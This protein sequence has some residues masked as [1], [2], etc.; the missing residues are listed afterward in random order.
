MKKSLAYIKSVYLS[1]GYISLPWFLNSNLFL[2]NNFIT[3]A[4]VCSCEIGEIFQDTFVEKNLRTTASDQYFSVRIVFKS[5]SMLKVTIVLIT[6]SNFKVSNR[7]RCK[8]RTLWIDFQW[9]R[10]SSGDSRSSFRE[11][12]LNEVTHF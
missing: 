2:P 5:I 10:I 3:P 6:K 4:N 7:W 11:G 1:N 9:V 8:H 12:M